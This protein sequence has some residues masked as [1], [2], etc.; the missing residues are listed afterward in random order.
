ML[1]QDDPEQLARAV[2]LGRCI[3]THNR[4]HYE[5]L[6]RDYLAAQRKH[7]GI[8]IASRRNAYELTRRIAV[9]LNALA[10]DEIENQLL[11]L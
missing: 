4:I 5:Q 7:F 3:F 1:G 10:A 6:H 2:I 8:I 9:L 11:Y